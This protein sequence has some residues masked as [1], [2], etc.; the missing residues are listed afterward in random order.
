MEGQGDHRVDPGHPGHVEV[1][2]DALAEDYLGAGGDGGAGR[3]CR[4]ED[5]P[6]GGV[7]GGR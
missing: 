1:V 6:R 2:G 3:R 4:G 7:G 5:G